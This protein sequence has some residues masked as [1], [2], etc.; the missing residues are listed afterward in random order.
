[1]PRPSLS[2]ELSRLQQQGLIQFD[3]QGVQI[4]DPEGLEE[5]LWD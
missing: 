1:V 3:Q 5:L 4:I 2:R